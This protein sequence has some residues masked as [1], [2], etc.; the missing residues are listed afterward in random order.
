[1]QQAE[2]KYQNAGFLSAPSTTDTSDTAFTTTNG[3]VD[4]SIVIGVT[5]G[6]VGF[7][8]ITALLIAV[9]TIAW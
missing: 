9:I 2:E 7:I 1:M 6:V 4:Q 5:V 8:L 3:Q